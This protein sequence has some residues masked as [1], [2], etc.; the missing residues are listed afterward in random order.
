MKLNPDD[1]KI[2]LKCL[3]WDAEE[4]KWYKAEIIDINEDIITLKDI[5]DKSQWQG[6]IWETNSVDIL[7]ITLYKTL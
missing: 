4:C 3:A 1:I 7:D 5:D 6:M 2:G